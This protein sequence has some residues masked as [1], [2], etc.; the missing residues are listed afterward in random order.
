M[1][2]PASSAT[3]MP[4]THAAISSW[5]S[6]IS[7]RRSSAAAPWTTRPEQRREPARR[8]SRIES[9]QMRRRNDHEIEIRIFA[10]KLSCGRIAARL[11]LQG[12]RARRSRETARGA[13]HDRGGDAAAAPSGERP[14]L[15]ARGYLEWMDPAMA[16]K[17]RLEGIPSSRRTR[18]AGDRAR[19]E[20]ASLGLQWA[21]SRAEIEA[22]EGDKVRI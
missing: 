2:A 20:S 17:R 21:E 5:R 4:L 15:S 12:Q 22:V 6:P 13:Y 1:R 19:H 18:G 16:P 11:G 9:R 10:A 8:R 7:T 14:K 3:S